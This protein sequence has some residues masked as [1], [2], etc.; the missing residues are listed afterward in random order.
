MKGTALVNFIVLTSKKCRLLIVDL[1]LYFIL[2]STMMLYLL[3]A[4]WTDERN[5]FHERTIEHLLQIKQLDHSCLEMY[6]VL[7]MNKELILFLV[8]N[9]VLNDLRL[10]MMFK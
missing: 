5:R 9:M 2:F 3:S 10:I 1:G 8:K 7:S 6:R 4:Q